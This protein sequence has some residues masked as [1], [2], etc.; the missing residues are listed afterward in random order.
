M[1]P[2][3]PSLTGE[4][5]EHQW[6]FGRVYAV[7][8]SGIRPHPAGPWTRDQL[9]A[10]TRWPRPGTADHVTPGTS[11]LRSFRPVDVPEECVFLLGDHRDNSND[12]RTFGPLGRDL[13][14]GKVVM[15][16]AG[17]RP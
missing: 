10:R 17:S 15:V 9:D 4:L 1:S 6:P 16:L 5:A 8:P 14:G 11:A 3:T 12:S 7:V 2:V 13:I